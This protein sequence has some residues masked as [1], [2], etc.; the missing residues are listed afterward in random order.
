[1]RSPTSD[2]AV[3]EHLMAARPAHGPEHPLGRRRAARR[4]VAASHGR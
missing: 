4:P 1:V 2:E 3:P